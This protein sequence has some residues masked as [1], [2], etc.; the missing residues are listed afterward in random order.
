MPGDVVHGRP[1][2]TG[3]IRPLAS[4]RRRFVLLARHQSTAAPHR[5]QSAGADGVLQSRQVGARRFRLISFISRSRDMSSR[6]VDINYQITIPTVSHM[7]SGLTYA[8]DHGKSVTLAASR[9]SSEQLFPQR[10]VCRRQGGR[11]FS[12]LDAIIAIDLKL[13]QT[14][15]YCMDCQLSL[16]DSNTDLGRWKSGNRREGVETGRR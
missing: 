8:R 9:S 14:I 11:L 13:S 10:T 7:A 2:P 4:G 16:P 6:V 12:G 1:V 5:R 15:S 3:H